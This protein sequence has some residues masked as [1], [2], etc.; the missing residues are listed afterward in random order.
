MFDYKSNQNI[1]N[2]FAISLFFI[3]LNNV[4]SPTIKYIGFF[5]ILLVLVISSQI[6]C[7]AFIKGSTLNKSKKKFAISYI[8]L[9]VFFSL[10]ILFNPNIRGFITLGELVLIVNFFLLYSMIN[11]E[12]INLNYKFIF[13]CL[14]IYL[15]IYY[16]GIFKY[17]INTG[18]YSS[19]YA[20]PNTLG[21]AALL[22]MGISLT[23][24]NLSGKKV[25][26]LY[27]ILFSFIIYAS[28]TRSSVFAG[29]IAI[30]LYIFYK[31]ISKNKCTWNI[32]MLVILVSIILFI[33]IYPN[34]NQLPVYDK[35]NSIVYRKTS[36]T[37]LWKQS[38]KLILEKPLFCYGTGAQLSSITNR[39]LSAYNL[40][41]QILFQN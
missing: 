5:S 39:Q 40:Y 24:Y 36:K 2:I 6:L 41:I 15:V 4:S 26:F 35:W 25:Y 14:T 3:T 18:S 23:I 38:M 20:N 27:A 10:G 9:I 34:I 22:F 37:L 29:I 7:F 19:I 12:K 21:M 28:G 17:G 32:A 31:Q 16:F 8:L 11:Y 1:F 30:V 33:Y 13:I